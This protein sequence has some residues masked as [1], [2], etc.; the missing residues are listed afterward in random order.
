V[1]GWKGRLGKGGRLEI[2]VAGS[3]RRVGHI[4]RV[5]TR[6]VGQSVYSCMPISRYIA[7]LKVE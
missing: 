4:V 1:R 7:H 6:L 3:C 5:C 2:V